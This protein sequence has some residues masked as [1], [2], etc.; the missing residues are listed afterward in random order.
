MPEVANIFANI[1]GNL[2]Q[3]LF[4]MLKTTASFRIER[5]VSQG[6][7]S[8]EGFWYDQEQHEWILLIRGAARDLS[9]GLAL[10]PGAASSTSVSSSG[11]ETQ[12]EAGRQRAEISK[13]Q[14]M[15]GFGRFYGPF[16]RSITC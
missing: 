3:E 4:E 6:H 1:P 11:S 14:E 15:A 9:R 8:A 7:A 16:L 10:T 5:I 12:I 2:P 13:W